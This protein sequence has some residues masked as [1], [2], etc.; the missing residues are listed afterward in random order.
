MDA[1]TAAHDTAVQMIDTSIVLHQHAVRVARNKEQLM[2]RFGCGALGHGD[3]PL[4]LF[5]RGWRC[6]R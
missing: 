3:F 4:P 6:E 5:G 1:L 2:G